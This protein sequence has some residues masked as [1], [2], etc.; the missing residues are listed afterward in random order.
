MQETF[1]DA[2]KQLLL[3]NSVFGFFLFVFKVNDTSDG[4]SVMSDCETTRIKKI[5]WGSFLTF[6]H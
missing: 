4:G 3:F 1:C 6:V 2:D 5:E